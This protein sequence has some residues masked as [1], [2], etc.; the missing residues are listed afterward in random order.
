[1]MTYRVP[2]R[3]ILRITNT[4]RQQVRSIDG[5]HFELRCYQLLTDPSAVIV[6][7]GHVTATAAA[8]AAVTLDVSLPASSTTVDTATAASS[9]P[10]TSDQG[11]S[12]KRRKEES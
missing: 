2:W 9:S 3:L 5:Q 1:M 4:L 6:L 7:V 8:D 11:R 12:R 10:S